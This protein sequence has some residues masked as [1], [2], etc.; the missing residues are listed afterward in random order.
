MKLDPHFGTEEEF[1]SFVKEAH[2][3]GMKIILDVAFNHTG[4]TFW[5][6]QDGMKKGP[7]SKYYN[8]YDW[9]KWPLPNSLE[10]SNFKL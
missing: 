4:E 10:S 5:A 7:D 9:N 8:W 2:H 3:R 6:F 1:K